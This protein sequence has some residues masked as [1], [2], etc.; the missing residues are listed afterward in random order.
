MSV[1][2]FVSIHICALSWITSIAIIIAGAYLALAQ[3]AL[4]LSVLV[5]G[6]YI[7]PSL[8]IPTVPWIAMY[9]YQ[10]IMEAVGGVKLR[11]PPKMS[12]APTLYVIH[13]HG[14]TST[15]TGLALVERCKR[16]ERVALAVA[17]LLH[18]GNPMMRLLMNL[19]GV[20][21]VSC[22][23]PSISR[24]MQ[25]G[26][27]VAI[28]VGGFDEMLRNSV[29]AEVVIL[30]Y[31]KGFVKY[32]ISHGYSLTPVFCFGESL[33]YTNVLPLS[34]GVRNFLA[35]W[36]IPILLPRGRTWWNA[37]PVELPGGGVI[38]FGASIPVEKTKCPPR[39]LIDT[40]HAEYV[41]HLSNLYTSHNPYPDR[42][43]VLM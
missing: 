12:S 26:Q 23:G 33:M 34:S 9:I 14:I 3:E 11:F 43:L 30:K 8:V 5:A 22:T 40:V 24:R 42:P 19:I 27:S 4:L 21:L 32:A 15:L 10:G 18:W 7:I 36:K 39:S 37:M 31:R 35:K 25:Q 38:A 16:G 1:R 28:I 20:D 6:I 2:A 13:P 29:D 17:P 41:A